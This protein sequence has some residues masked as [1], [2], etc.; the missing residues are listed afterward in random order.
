M[1]GR[2][3]GGGGNAGAV[4]PPRALQLCPPHSLACYF[5]GPS[6]TPGKGREGLHRRVEIYMGMDLL[7][8]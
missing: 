4:L 8:Q 5:R 1:E 2:E 7:A 3:E 6:Q